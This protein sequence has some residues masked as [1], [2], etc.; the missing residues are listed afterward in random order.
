MTK[1]LIVISS[2]IYVRNYLTTD[3]FSRLE[4]E[5]DCHFIADRNI[6]MKDLVAEKPGFQGFYGISSA[7]EKK[8]QQLFNLMMWRYRKRS[9]TFLY[10]W[11]RNSQWHLVDQSRGRWRHAV[12]VIRWVF[13]S[14]GN[15]RGMAVPLLEIGSYSRSLLE[16]L[17]AGFH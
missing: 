9:R 12:S 6:S 8:H 16:L 5:F 7:L 14:L 4:Q 2:D 10:R 1:L 3:A 13:S 17:N 15:P 11:L